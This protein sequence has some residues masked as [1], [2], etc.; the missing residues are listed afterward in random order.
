MQNR[1]NC[2]HHGKNG[3]AKIKMEKMENEYKTELQNST[4]TCRIWAE[5][6]AECRI[7][8]NFSENLKN[9]QKSPA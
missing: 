5:S 2:Y 6:C 4:T 7:N 9:P 1:P 3:I 8:S